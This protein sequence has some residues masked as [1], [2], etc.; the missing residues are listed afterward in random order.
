[1]DQ[2]QPIGE[3]LLPVAGWP[4]E[5]NVKDMAKP[6][7]TTD[8]TDKR[9]SAAERKADDLLREAS[10][11]YH[12]ALDYVYELL[13]EGRELEALAHRE[14]CQ[15]A[16]DRERGITDEWMDEADI[17]AAL[18]EEVDAERV[19]EEAEKKKKE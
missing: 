14:T 10:R 3:V 13:D 2:A 5:F 16:Y 15:K 17:M 4:G 12:E 6:T 19:A 11:K 8:R 18:I 9:E 1:M 7:R